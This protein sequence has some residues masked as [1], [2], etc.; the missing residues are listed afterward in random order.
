MKIILIRHG[1]AEAY[2]Q[3][4]STR[5]LTEFGKQQA[6]ATAQYVWQTYAPD[7]FVVSPYVRA[8]QTLAAFNQQK[9]QLTDELANKITD[10][11]GNHLPVHVLEGI[12]PNGDAEQALQALD[13]LFCSIPEFTALQQAGS[14][15]DKVCVVVCH[16]PIVAKLAALL[17]ED[18]PIAYELAE[19]RVIETTVD[20]ALLAGFGKQIDRFSP[21]QYPI[22]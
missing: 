12:T 18:I 9:N 1:Q 6:N 3:P 13:A 10:T 21:P 11:Q 16:M 7:V 22:V 15:L 5:Q 14:T 20:G 8:Q 19:A 2:K 17:T 4:D